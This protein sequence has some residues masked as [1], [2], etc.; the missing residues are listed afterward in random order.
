MSA[1]VITVTFEG[2]HAATVAGWRGRELLEHMTGRI[3]LWMPLRRGWYTRPRT[4][5]DLIAEAERRGWRVEIG[6]PDEHA[7]A[8][9]R[10]VLW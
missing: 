8:H 9:A 7:A 3:P 1:P 10:G 4:A 6:Q 2:P 5:R